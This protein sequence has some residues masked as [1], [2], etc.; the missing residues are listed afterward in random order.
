L[1][2][3]IGCAQ[4]ERIDELLTAKRRIFENYKALLHELPLSMNPEPAGT[5]NGYWMPTI[6]VDEDVAFDRDALLASFKADNIDGRVF[7]W[8]LS[9][10]PSFAGNRANPVSRSLSPRALNLPSYHDLTDGEM[11]RVASHVFAALGRQI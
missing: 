9:S 7:F 10:L 3:A 4:I 5:R 1:Q 6:V 11:E 2:A 8:P